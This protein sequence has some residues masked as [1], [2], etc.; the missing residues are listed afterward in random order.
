MVGSRIAAMA[1]ALAIGAG[2]LAGAVEAQAPPAAGDIPYKRARIDKPLPDGKVA[3]GSR[4][5]LAAWLSDPVQR[6]RHFKLGSEH[7]AETLMV[8]TSERRVLKLTLPAD[9]VFEDR[10]PRIADVDGDG[11]DEVIVVR[12]YLK[13][14]A[15]LAVASA[16][17]GVLQITAETR[18]LGRPLQWLNP[19]GVGDLD[20]DGRPD[21]ALVTT[22]HVSGELQILTLRDGRLAEI[23]REDDVSNHAPGSRHL[24]LSAIADFDGDG[25][26]D[27]AIPSGSRR[28]IR[29]LSFKGGRVREIS[30]V[31]LP[32][33]ASEDFSVVAKDGRTAVRVGFSAGR[34]M[35]VMP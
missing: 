35:I 29:F 9:S 3:R 26:A 32:A 13:A 21:I 17:G 18:P 16:K 25:V 5:I 33:A 22:P 11:E 27:L 20:D 6:Y 24:R 15:A 10:E 34:S 23:A 4:N 7:E 30:R 31:P 1:G 19:A 12:S 14:G 28:E 8:S 2:V